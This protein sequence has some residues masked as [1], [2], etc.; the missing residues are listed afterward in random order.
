MI[1]TPNAGPTAKGGILGRRKRMQPDVDIY[2]NTWRQGPDGH[3][4]YVRCRLSEAR[5]YAE[6]AALAECGNDPLKAGRNTGL[7]RARKSPA[8]SAKG[9]KNEHPRC[10]YCGALSAYPWGAPQICAGCEKIRNRYEPQAT[11]QTIA[12]RADPAL[13]W[14]Q[15]RD[16]AEGW[17]GDDRLYLRVQRTLANRERAAAAE[18]FQKHGPGRLEREGPAVKVSEAIAKAK[19]AARAKFRRHPLKELA[20]AAE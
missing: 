5:K 4:E 17:I 13:S 9:N 18:Q 11:L 14:N 8:A 1:K 12:E 16:S 20:D 6:A 2:V 3:F 10:R 15:A 19:D 7:F